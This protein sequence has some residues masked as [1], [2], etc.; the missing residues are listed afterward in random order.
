MFEWNY[1]DSSSVEFLLTDC[2]GISDLSR[3]KQPIAHGNGCFGRG[4]MQ[5]YKGRTKTT[6]SGQNNWS[7][8][9]TTISGKA[10]MT[11]SDQNAGHYVAAAK[12]VYGWTESEC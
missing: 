6:I 1:I 12:G 10:K 9:K 3:P 5:D 2:F 7:L 11:I 4:F 8:A